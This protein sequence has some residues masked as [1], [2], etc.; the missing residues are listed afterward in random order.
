MRLGDVSNS[1][2]QGLTDDVVSEGFQDLF[3]VHISGEVGNK[4][5]VLHLASH[6][7]DLPSREVGEFNLVEVEEGIG[8]TFFISESHKSVSIE[9]SKCQIYV[10]MSKAMMSKVRKGGA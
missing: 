9:Y 7:G 5:F 8:S 1:R 10:V 3:L 4:Q 2:R 6:N